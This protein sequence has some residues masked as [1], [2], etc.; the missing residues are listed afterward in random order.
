MSQSK[1]LFISPDYLKELTALNANVDDVVIRAN[2]LNVQRMY[3]E[4]VLGT[5]LYDAIVSK[6]SGAGLTGDYQTLVN[7]WCAS[8][9]AWYTMVE[10]IP[11]IAVDIARGGVYRGNAENSSTASIQE[12]NLLR[13]GYRNNAERFTD[14]LGDYLCSNSN[15]FPEYSTNSN[16][17]LRPQN[18]SAFNGIW[19]GGNDETEYEKRTGQRY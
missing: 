11:T 9:V 2:I 4:P 12:I 10:L 17:D 15:L 6:I 19:L 1:S 8:A 3:I 13:D 14:R 18:T 7:K 5:D 16:E